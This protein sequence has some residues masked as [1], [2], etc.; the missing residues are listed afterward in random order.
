MKF[1]LSLLISLF[2]SASYAEDLLGPMLKFDNDSQQLT[3]SKVLK[4]FGYHNYDGNDNYQNILRLRYYNPLEVGEWRGRIRLDTSYASNYN[5][6]SSANNA[7]QYSA[8]NT[9]I[10]IWGAKQNFFYSP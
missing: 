4:F 6:I 3:N 7:G 10:T 8:G 9:L 5:S 2:V 1:L